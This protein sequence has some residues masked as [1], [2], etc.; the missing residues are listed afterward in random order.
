M[1]TAFA[2]GFIIPFAVNGLREKRFVYPHWLF[3]MHYAGTI[4]T[5]MTFVFSMVFILPFNATFAL[6]GSNL[7]LHLICPIMILIAFFLVESGYRITRKN[8]FLCTTPLL[9]YASVYFVMVVIIG[10]ERGGWRDLYKLNTFVPFYISVPAGLLLAFPIASAIR[11]LSNRF[12]QH[13]QD[14][15]LSH[16]KKDMDPIEVSIEIFGLGRHYGLI[17][18][19]SGLSIPY[20]LLEMLADRY[21]IDPLKLVKVYET[22]LLDAVSEREA[23]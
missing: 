20:D 16:W 21:A 13:R 15:M 22:G 3:L 12:A 10:T 6:G 23:S 9:V 11:A 4:C 19:K 1:L 14:L 17:G 5:T 18:D 7:Y 2:A 8:V